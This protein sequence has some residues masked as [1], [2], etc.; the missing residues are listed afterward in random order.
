MEELVQDW[1][2]RAPPP[3]LRPF[4]DRYIGYRLTGVPPGLHRG[5][6]SRNMTFIVSVGPP[7]DVVTQTDPKQQPA[8]YGCVVSGLQAS[9]A[10]IA[11]NGH[12]E[13]VAIE[14]SPL[15]SRAILGMPAREL[16][17]RSHE[18]ED[19]VGRVGG[20][21]WERTQHAGMWDERFATCDD[22]LLRLWRL[23][24]TS[25]E[26]RESWHDLVAS[27]GQ[28]SV[29]DLAEETG[30]SRQHL[31]RLFRDEFGLSPKLA[32]RIVRF[33]RARRM[34]Q[35]VPPFVTI[36]QVA[37]SVGYYDQAHMNRDFAK[38][39]GCTPTELAEDVPNFQE[40]MKAQLP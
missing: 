5:L 31:T 27:G 33:E 21:L 32:A 36:A 7:I 2:T 28:I 17:D 6:P 23:D 19:V 16:W 10:L 12:Q 39:A 30:Y 35:S 8:R 9:P 26:L 3:Q 24:E 14:L 22:I 37:T 34:L 38:L 25:P 40:E 20:E 4:V 18:L 29:Q 11:H 13:G 1:V 15:G